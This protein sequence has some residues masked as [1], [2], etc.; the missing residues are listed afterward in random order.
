VLKA[1]GVHYIA[2]EYLVSIDNLETHHID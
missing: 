1:D 2:S